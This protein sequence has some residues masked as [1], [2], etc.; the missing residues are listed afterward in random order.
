M[1][2]GQVCL[3]AQSVLIVVRFDTVFTSALK[4]SLGCVAVFKVRSRSSKVAIAALGL[5]ALL[6][7]PVAGFG[8][9]D[10]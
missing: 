4:L 8:S 1:P 7:T 9:T 10:G 2:I 6:S 5:W 3:R